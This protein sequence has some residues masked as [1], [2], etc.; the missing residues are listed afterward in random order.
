MP[1]LSSP[2]N[3]L[4]ITVVGFSAFAGYSDVF[5]VVDYKATELSC[6]LWL[7]GEFG[8]FIAMAAS[9]SAVIILRG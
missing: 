6:K 5:T 8:V 9:I 2:W 4:A 7:I 1:A 3:R